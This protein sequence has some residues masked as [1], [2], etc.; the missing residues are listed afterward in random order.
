MLEQEVEEIK[1]V[2][3]NEKSI[4]EQVC[5]SKE[6]VDDTKSGTLNQI[7]NI[8][9]KFDELDEIIKRDRVGN[10]SDII[11]PNHYLKNNSVDNIVSTFKINKYYI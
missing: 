11:H 4:S 1:E 6:Y 3:L 5:D 7:Y 10:T 2:E 8:I 9:Q